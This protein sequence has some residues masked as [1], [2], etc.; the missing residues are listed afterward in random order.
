MKV[1]FIHHSGLVGGAGVSLSNIVKET[2]KNH[3]VTVCVPTDPSDMMSLLQN[4]FDNKLF[5]IEN[6]GQRIGA[7]TWYSGGNN[8][9]SL[10][11]IYRILL[12]IWQWR[13]WNKFIERLNPDL[14][15]CNSKILCWMGQLPAIRKRKSLCFVRETMKE[16]PMHFMNRLIKSCLEMF[17]GVVFI[18][19][20]DR[21]NEN[22]KNTHTFVV[23]NYVDVYRFDNMLERIKACEQLGVPFKKFNVLY[24]G[25]TFPL[26]GFDLAVR[27]V[28]ECPSNVHLLVAGMTIED[29]QKVKSSSLKQ[30]AR[31]WR[32][33][34]ENNDVDKR[35][36]ILGKQM[37]MSACYAACDVLLFPMREPHQARP[38][39]E[40]G[41]FRKPV[42]ITDFD[43]IHDDVQNG[44]NGYLVQCG[45]VKDIVEKIQELQTY[46]EKNKNMGEKN[47]KSYLLKHSQERSMKAFNDCLK[48]LTTI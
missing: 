23:P 13:F 37:N 34:I 8:W 42:I 24:V 7:I 46:P 48:E 26:K 38:V 44:V 6:Y 30:Y 28:L 33:Y 25:G 47:Y 31:T 19:E 10:R 4:T 36:H 22:L 21:K 5:D 3:I 43:C 39:F 27:A 35:I 32:D 2:A 29:A 16:E 1:L 15:I 20:F 11:F 18:S 9:F 17:T 12:I 40:A 41:Y 45:D 14:I